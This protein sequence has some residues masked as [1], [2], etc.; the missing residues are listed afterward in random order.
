MITTKGVLLI[1]Q[2]LDDVRLGC[3][4]SQAMHL[5]CWGDLHAFDPKEPSRKQLVRGGKD[6]DE[7]IDEIYRAQE[8][9][10]GVDGGRVSIGFVSRKVS[11]LERRYMAQTLEETERV[12]LEAI[13]A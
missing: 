5:L 9:V 6:W 3:T 4:L 10:F 11:P 2:M 7:M 1:G 13:A 8:R 12:L